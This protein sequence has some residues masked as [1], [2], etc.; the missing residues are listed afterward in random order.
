MIVTGGMST[1]ACEWYDPRTSSTNGGGWREMMAMPMFGRYYHSMVAVD[2]YTAYIIGGHLNNGTIDDGKDDARI[3]WQLDVRGTK[4]QWIV[5]DSK[6]GSL[7][8]TPTVAAIMGKGSMSMPTLPVN[9]VAPALMYI[10]DTLIAIQSPLRRVILKQPPAALYLPLYGQH[11]NH[12]R[13][14]IPFETHES[15]RK[16]GLAAVVVP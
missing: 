14:W 15:I 3:I 12:H 1:D 16:T 5:H 9:L 13:E 6:S 2:D 8:T 4:D 10:D 11:N 7:T